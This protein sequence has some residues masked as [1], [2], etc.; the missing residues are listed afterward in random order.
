LS[1][2][3]LKHFV[4]DI[5][6]DNGVITLTKPEEFHP[7]D[8]FLEL[9]MKELMRASWSIPANLEF[10]SGRTVSV[11]LAMDLG[12]G[13]AL[14][15]ATDGEHKIAV[16]E[17]ALEASLGFGIQGE[18][19]GHFGRIKSMTIGDYEIH[20]VIAA[21]A[22]PGS[23][24]FH[25]ITVGMQIFTRF[26]MVYDYPHQRMFLKP[27]RTFDDPFEYNMSGLSMR[28]GRG[29]YLDILRVHENS[30]AR[31]L[32]LKISDRV[33]KINGRKAIDYDTYELRPLLRQEGATIILDVLI[34][35]EESQVELTLRRLI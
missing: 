22:E 33:L 3:F 12:Y 35:G 10:I 9:P 6:F 8:G 23:N 26:H 20:G 34:D 24:S 29:D 15:I 32:G 19:K 31:D 21:F 1:A 2:V 4:V 11:D 28:R 27:G 16:P 17:K 30:P 5:D 14:E 18:T 7:A 13:N 25:E